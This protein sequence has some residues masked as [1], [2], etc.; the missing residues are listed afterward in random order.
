MKQ[1]ALKLSINEQTNCTP[2]YKF[3]TGYQIPSC[4]CAE[5]GVQDKI[6]I[7]REDALKNSVPEF[8]L[9]IKFL[10][11]TFSIPIEKLKL[12]FQSSDQVFVIFTGLI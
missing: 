7:M 2:D 1:K 8:P 11:S 9:Q 10:V 4:Q 3:S 12:V 5:I 6:P